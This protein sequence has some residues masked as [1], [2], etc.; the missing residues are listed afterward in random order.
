MPIPMYTL[1]GLQTPPPPKH[2]PGLYHPMLSL[3]AFIIWRIQCIAHYT[4]IYSITALL[5]AHKK[6]VID[7]I[8]IWMCLAK[9]PRLIFWERKPIA[10]IFLSHLGIWSFPQQ[11]FRCS[12]KYSTTCEYDPNRIFRNTQRFME[13]ASE[14]ILFDL[15]LSERVPSTRVDHNT[16]S[17]RTAWQLHS[18]ACVPHSSQPQ[19]LMMQWR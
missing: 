8:R 13:K 15:L 11:V 4:L 10:A 2:L 16:G 9:S 18:L 12:W 1:T 7:Q 3:V 14:T 17:G 5:R 6:Q 19:N